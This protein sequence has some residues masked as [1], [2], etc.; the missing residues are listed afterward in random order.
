M[1][2]LSYSA[3]AYVKGLVYWSVSLLRLF[4]FFFSFSEVGTHSVVPGTSFHVVPEPNWTGFSRVCT[5]PSSWASRPACVPPPFL[6][7]AEFSLSSDLNG[8]IISSHPSFPPWPRLLSLAL[9]SHSSVLLLAAEPCFVRVFVQ[10]CVFLRVQLQGHVDGVCG[11]VS[12]TELYTIDAAFL[13][14][15][16]AKEILLFNG[17]VCFFFF[18]VDSFKKYL[19]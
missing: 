11:V 15:F 13:Q 14:F 3:Y 7:L 17:F 8:S 10:V 16:T 12:C 5:H 19:I 4:F 6:P 18:F 9:W 2:L 1:L